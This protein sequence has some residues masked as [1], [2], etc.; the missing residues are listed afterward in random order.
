M[1][2]ISILLSAFI[3]LLLVSVPGNGF[4]Q[5]AEEETVKDKIQLLEKQVKISQAKLFVEYTNKI[6]KYVTEIGS[7]QNMI[8]ETDMKQLK[9]KLKEFHEKKSRAFSEEDKEFLLDI[10]VE[11]AKEFQFIKE[12]TD[13]TDLYFKGLTHSDNKN[14]AVQNFFKK[15]T[16]SIVGIEEKTDWPMRIL[17][18]LLIGVP[19]AASMGVIFMFLQFQNTND[20]SPLWTI[21]GLLGVISLLLF[22]FVLETILI[23]A[24]V[25]GAF[26]IIALTCTIWAQA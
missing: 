13:I 6:R 22:L 23:P 26:V 21:F 24:I 8:T 16:G 5:E 2:K 10:E 3:I 17:W 25:A 12:C 14:Y 15:H 20:D 19:F 9:L 1:K 7:T 18:G 4:C 11:H